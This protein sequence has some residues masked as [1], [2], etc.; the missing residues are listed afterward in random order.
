MPIQ[1]VHLVVDNPDDVRGMPLIDVYADDWNG[2]GQ[3]IADHLEPGRY[4][5]NVTLS[6]IDDDWDEL[7][8]SGHLTLNADNSLVW[9]LYT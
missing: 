7:H 3:T 8:S 1:T 4:P 6:P 9:D 2:I 5:V